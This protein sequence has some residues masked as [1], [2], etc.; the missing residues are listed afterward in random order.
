MKTPKR[1]TPYSVFCP[2]FFTWEGAN[3]DAMSAQRWKRKNKTA[4]Y[5]RTIARILAG[6]NL[7]PELQTAYRFMR[8]VMSQ[9]RKN[10][11]ELRFV[12]CLQLL[13][14]HF[15]M[16]AIEQMDSILNKRRRNAHKQAENGQQA[17]N[18]QNA[19]NAKRG[20]LLCTGAEQS[21]ERKDE[22]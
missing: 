9:E 4:Q 5:K 14:K 3:D 6:E 15:S 22:A 1:K 21:T 8:L 20:N 11:D 12:Q 13:A 19:E 10:A 18:A 2:R 17:C 16:L 7:A